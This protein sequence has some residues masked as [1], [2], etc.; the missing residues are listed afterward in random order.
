MSCLANSRT[1]RSLGIRAALVLLALW[2]FAAAAA[3]DVVQPRPGIDSCS[4]ALAA[5]AT[6][7]DTGTPNPSGVRLVVAQTV[8]DFT[9]CFNRRNWEGVLALSAPGFRESM[10]GA[11][12]SEAFLAQ[13][14]LLDS[15]GLL[16]E[17]RI[18]SIEENGTTGNQLATLVVTWQGWQDVH[19][20]LWRVQRDDSHWRLTGRSIQTPHLN[21][22][23]VGIRYRIEAGGL[24]A[25]LQQIVN[26]GIVLLSFENTI[27]LDAIAL[28]LRVEPGRTVETVADACNSPG[29]Q[30]FEPVGRIQAPAGETV[31]VPLQDIG[32]GRYAVIVDV[33]P[34]SGKSPVLVERI[35][36]LDVAV[37]AEI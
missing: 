15:R 27:E 4:R 8:M 32:P 25:P 12:D 14:E 37:P 34:C 33:D 2:S 7:V 35:M 29:T 24:V 5:L 3:A 28:I 1:T 23:A 17:L 20:E 21:G 31:T 18:Q 30:Q 19:R 13:V 11:G 26:P 36:L 16:P 22:Q 9:G 10:F 6:P